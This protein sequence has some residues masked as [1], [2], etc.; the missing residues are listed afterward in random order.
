MRK[1]IALAFV[2][3]SSYGLSF[4]K[5]MEALSRYNVVLVH[6]AAPESEGFEDQCDGTV[7]SAWD[8]HNAWVVDYTTQDGKREAPKSLGGAAGMLGAYNQEGDVKLTLWLDSAVFEDTITY[9]S[10]YIYIQRAFANPAASPAHNAHEIGDRTWKG[11]NNCSVRRSLFEEAQEVRVQ[12]STNLSIMRNDSKAAYR[13]IPSRNILIAHSMGGVASHEYVTDTNV[14]NN[15]VD[16]VITLDSPHEGTGSLNLL[17]DMRDYKQQAKEASSQFLLAYV[18]SA[19]RGV[20]DPFAATIL[21]D[22]LAMTYGTSAM[23]RAV[24]TLVDKLALKDDYGF[25]EEDSLTQYIYPASEGITSLKNRTAHENMPMV[26]LLAGKGGMTFSDPNEGFLKPALNFTVPEAL[27]APIGNI[28]T[29]LKEGDGSAAAK[30]VNSM[31]GLGLGYLGAITLQDIGTTLIPEK[32]GL[33]EETSA[34]IDPNVD[35]RRF[36][37][38]AAAHANEASIGLLVAENVATLA[39]TVA[40]I[41]AVDGITFGSPIVGAE[42]KFA[43]ALAGA[44]LLTLEVM[45]SGV[46]DIL[47]SHE[48]AKARRMLDTLYSAEFSYNKVM[49]GDVSGKTL[50]MED[51]LYEKPFVNLGLFVS[52]D[53]LRDVDAGC[54]YEADKADKEQL[55][56]IGLYGANGDIVDMAGRRNYK[57]F[58]KSPLA[59]KSSSDWSSI[60][61]KMD[62]WERV[63]GLKPDGGENPGGVP[64]RHVE[65]YNV[66]AITVD[67]WIEKYSF[68]VDDLMPHRLRQIRLNFNYKEEIAWECDI[69]KA[70]TSSTAC[71]VFGRSGGGSWGPV[72]SRNHAVLSDGR[73]IVIMDTIRGV[74]HPVKKNGLFEFEPRKYGFDN[75]LAI[76]KDNQNTVAISTV[77]KIGAS[78][79]QRFYYLYKATANKLESVWPRNDVVLNK[80]KDFE[81]YASALGYE[82]FYVMNAWDTFL[83]QSGD[84]LGSVYSKSEMDMELDTYYDLS[85]IGTTGVSADGL[86]YDSTSAYFTSRQSDSD[87]AEGDYVW[88]FYTNIVNSTDST[89]D[90]NSYEIPFKVDRT[91]PKFVVTPE[92]DFTNPSKSAFVARYKWTDSVNEPD[93]RAMRW[94]LESGCAYRAGSTSSKDVTCTNSMDLT[95]FENVGS[96]DFAMPW[97]SASRSFAK[98]QGDGLYR[99]KVFAVDNAVSDRASYVKMSNLENAIA[100]NPSKVDANLWPV[101][102]DSLNVSTEYAAFIVDVTA[103]KLENVVAG[104]DSGAYSPYA[105]LARPARDSK[106][107]YAT[108]DSLLG[109][110]YQV[111]ENLNGRER[112]PVTVLWNFVHLGDTSKVDRAGDSVWVKS[113]GIATAEWREASGMRLEDGDYEIRA[114]VSDA[115]K[116]DS[117]YRNLAKIRV[118]KTAPTIFGLTSNRL[119]YPD[120]V[121]EFSA[122]I[123]VNENNDVATNR[124]GMRC[125]YRVTDG[126]NSMNWK[127]VSNNVLGNDSVTFEMESVGSK[128]GLRYLEAACVDAAGN[129]SLKTDIFYVGTRTPMISSPVDGDP[130]NANLVAIAGIAP[131]SGNADSMHTIYRLRY[132]VAGDTVW[133]TSNIFV[134]SSVQNDSLANVSKVSQ[135]NDG[136]LGYINRELPDGSLLSGTY[137]IEL[138]TFSAAEN[139]MGVDSLWT[140]DTAEVFFGFDADTTSDASL[141]FNIVMD[142]D[143]MKAGKDSLNLS[144]FLSGTFDGDYFMRI[145]AEDAKGVGVFEA[146]SS[147]VLKNPYYGLPSDTLSDTSA[148]WFYEDNGVYHLQWNGLALGDSLKIR[149]NSSSFDKICTSADSTKSLDKCVVRAAETPE[150]FDVLASLSYADGF[151][152]LSTVG[153]TDREMLV[154]G[155]SGH[156]VV[157]ANGAFAVSRTAILDTLAS[158]MRVYF[159]S[160]AKDGFYWVA[161]GISGDTL[162]PLATGWSV[163]PEMYGLKYKWDGILSTGGYPADGLMKIYA[164]AFENTSSNPHAFIDSA[165]VKIKLDPVEIA[166]ASKLPDFIALKKDDSFA[167]DGS[168]SASCEYVN[169]ALQQMSVSFGIKNRESKVDVYVMKNGKIVATLLDPTTVLRAHSNDSAYKV[170]WNSKNG[171]DMAELDEGLYQ[172]KIVATPV[173]G[174]ASA[175]KTASFN[176]KFAETMQDLSPDNP[177]DLSNRTPSIFVSEAFADTNYPGVFR[178]EP[179]ADYLI[180]SNVEYRYMNSKYKN[181][182]SING[183]ISG[184]QAVYGYEPKHFSLAIKRHRKELKLVVVQNINYTTFYVDC[185]LWNFNCEGKDEKRHNAIVVDTLHFTESDSFDTMY[186]IKNANPQGKNYYGLYYQAT[187]NNLEDISVFTLS[188]WDEFLKTYPEYADSAIVDKDYGVVKSAKQKIWGLNKVLS[189]PFN[190]PAPMPSES[191]NGAE[192]SYS[193]ENGDLGCKSNIEKDSVCTYEMYDMNAKLFEIKVFPIGDDGHFYS[194]WSKIHEGYNAYTYIT[195]AVE[196]KIPSEYWNADFGMDNLVNRTIRFDHTDETIYGNGSDGYLNALVHR[197]MIPNGTYFDGSAW[198]MDVGYGLLTPFEVQYLPMFPATW[199]NGTEY[200]D[201]GTNIFLF[202]DE[203]SNHP[204]DARF[205]ML[206]YGENFDTDYFQV[207]AVGNVAYG[208]SDASCDYDSTTNIIM[209][210]EAVRMCQVSAKSTNVSVQKTP[211]FAGSSGAMFYVGRNTDWTTVNKDDSTS[212]PADVNWRKS[213]K[214][215]CKASGQDWKSVLDGTKPC[216]KYYDIASKIHYYYEDYADSTW[217][218]IFINNDGTLKNLVNAPYYVARHP[219]NYLNASMVENYKKGIKG[220]SFDVKP[221]SSDYDTKTH[222]FFIKLDSIEKINTNLNTYENVVASVGNLSLAQNDSMI[223]WSNDSLHIATDFFEREFMYRKSEDLLAKP[224]ARPGKDVIPM[225]RLYSINNEWIKDVTLKSAKLMQLDSS[226]HSHLK[227]T[228]TFSGTSDIYVE[229]KSADSIVD[230]RVKEFVELQAFLKGGVTYQLSYLNDSAFYS[231]NDSISKVNDGLYHLGWF[232]VNRLNGNTQFLLT[233][234]GGTGSSYYFSKF[235]MIVGSDVTPSGS[236][237]VKSPLE[238]VEVTFPT[239]ALTE[240]KDV[241]VRISNPK[242][243]AFGVFNNLA[244]N[245][246]IVEV[247]PSM[248]FEN[249]AALPRIQMKVSREEMDA[250]HTTPETIK[251]YKVDF[252]NKEFVPLENALYGYLD[253]NGAALG[254]LGNDTAAVCSTPV[255]SRCGGGDSTWAYLLISAETRTFSVFTVLDSAVAEVPNFDLEILPEVAASTD[256]I[257]DVKGIS[258]FNLYVD[259]DSLWNDNGDSTAK[260]K[261]NYTLDS[262]GFAHIMLPVRGHDIDTNYVFVVAVSVDSTGKTS[263][264]PAAPAFARALTVNTAF[265]CSV[266]ED[267]LWLGLD[268]GYMAYGATCTHPGS[269]TVA[270]YRDGKLVTEIRGEIPDTIVYDGSKTFGSSRIGKIPSGVYESR[271][272]GVSAIG[273][274][275][276]VAGPLVY[277]DSMRPM[278]EN[279]DVVDSADILD[280]VFVVNADVYDS[281]S[282]VASVIVVPV[283]GSDTLRV[284]SAVPDSI[285][286]VK[287]PVRLSRKKLDNCTGCKLTLNFRVED[288]GHNHTDIKHATNKL[289]PFPAEIALW[290]PA[291]EETGKVAY[292]NLGTGHNL[293]L[294]G[295]SSSWL[296]DVGLYFSTQDSAVGVGSVDLGESSAYSFEARIKRGNTQAK[297]WN[298]V[299]GFSGKTGLNIELQMKNRD[300]RIVE[301]SVVWLAEKILPTEKE[302]F[303]IVVTVDSLNANFYVNGELA[304]SVPVGGAFAGLDRELDGTFSVGKLSTNS[305]IGNIADIRMYRGALVPEQV[306]ALVMPI[307]DDDET[308]PEAVI[309]AVDDMEMENG[310]E[311]LFSCSVAG[312]HYLASNGS[313]ASLKASAYVENSGDFNIIVYARST[314]LGSISV[315]AGENSATQRGTMSLSN[316]WRPVTISGITLNLK[317]GL[318]EIAL[319]VP[320]GIQIGGMALVT[321]AYPESAIAWGKS[322]YTSNSV[323]YG[324]AKKVKTYLR[325]EGYPETSTLRPR[326]RVVNTSD[327]PVNGFSVRY[328]FRGE[329]ASQVRTN[330]YWP[331]N[332]ESYPSV[333]SES[334]NTGYVEW[335]F[336][337]TIP[338]AGTVF[339][340]DGP[341]FGVYNSNYAPW[342]AL[343]DPSYV[344]MEFGAVPDKDGFFEDAGIIVLDNDDNLIG[345]ACAEMEDAISIVK[346]IKVIASDVRNDVQSSEIHVKVENVGNVS[347]EPFEMRYYFRV[348]GGLAVDYDVY[349]WGDCDR[350]LKHDVELK[351]YGGTLWGLSMRCPEPLNAGDSWK[352]P[353][354]ASLRIKD[355]VSIWNVSDDPSHRGLSFDSSEA[356]GICV[357]DSLGNLI[358]G[359]EP[360]SDLSGVKDSAY[361]ADNG[362]RAPGNSIPIVRTDDGLVLNLNAYTYLSLDL[363]NVV[364]MPIRNVF[365]GT[366]PPGEQM[367]RVNWSGINMNNTYLVLR[368]NGTIK[369]TKLLSLM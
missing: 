153:H 337:E 329:D 274:D 314:S 225:S 133:E 160:S 102:S 136:V 91:A 345:G 8:F 310:L 39:T 170:T 63:D 59:F 198:Q 351:N 357:Y 71:Q 104:A 40:N 364:G 173:D 197:N 10:D 299:L 303:H 96:Y 215:S 256:R 344:D 362:Y 72:F 140:T 5:P 19:M 304:K 260:V 87:P 240:K 239:S 121:T 114:L 58:R 218:R 14:Y 30:Y 83:K 305:F 181:G 204:Q 131:P 358:Y 235:D 213:M 164:E 158:Q 212:Y 53:S 323:A 11:N 266:P 190:F 130:I 50:L 356:S 322:S 191:P 32:S 201:N 122:T 332:V 313:G 335:K 84:S 206:F 128:H 34:F 340:G 209:A 176:V 125:Y 149:F 159:G 156:L 325:Y 363:V 229:F 178:Y 106:Y 108:Y 279:F 154:T 232:N 103:P 175:T 242:D 110:S 237:T 167:C 20:S 119:V 95:A 171:N 80:I 148:V 309:I 269:G 26:R 184:K 331:D 137:I 355:W 3:A 138:G 182:I 162:N 264:L 203:D 231:I 367:V 352:N 361:V 120:S 180:K 143:S 66:P 259:D 238:E 46:E 270:L 284:V 42:L 368:V 23:N 273:M 307:A 139:L 134:N 146:T 312:N 77:N 350:G 55:C 7:S 113:I 33:A 334:A 123:K 61:M 317:T 183:D 211:F 152:E 222:S 44:G 210:T 338:V 101:D 202:A 285:G 9:G 22:M 324:N 247:R 287:I 281:E 321:P 157:R 294:K 68:V 112:A 275:M 282:G 221:N 172:I 51:F 271:Y 99:I 220:F 216:Y 69:T 90:T 105:S 348:E 45:D 25:K 267:S 249:K 56:E 272:V 18:L 187:D 236:R 147:K 257:I 369:S 135:S 320:S 226:E 94:T 52:A 64:I 308:V 70:D 179:T 88:Q 43:I 258:N 353:V 268:N 297:T 192:Y 365:T 196:F 318:H 85:R 300:L 339:G 100:N 346:K 234:N 296:S 241:T 292:E 316:V 194:P 93:I 2:V 255:D 76:Q 117:L 161:N 214:N 92:Y 245:G 200:F 151:P 246:P 48:N 150:I 228:E 306:A 254:S 286:N 24:T 74:P 98:K 276:Q 115:A 145:Y 342:N 38:D 81:A 37:F 347:Q 251:L 169:F 4:A 333:H 278:V 126:T 224:L 291:R 60:G 265:A 219:L 73:E 166:L 298:R 62:R 75:L 31:T 328:Y 217:N 280:R 97:D 36:T 319:K 288:F 253:A 86:V 252:D 301:D 336:V 223:T 174:S 248:T 109:I 107:G 366:L 177:K 360:E 205:D 49:G 330:R 129:V 227:L 250:M 16:K 195:F 293:D 193:N 29:Q 359:E 302:W 13:S 124:T 163:N 262:T 1:L 116:N 243:H 79:T 311:R 207:L 27:S 189:S 28:V 21:V 165:V 65:R 54:F 6:G 261:L 82:E 341:H 118:D 186:V 277:T 354:K 141:Q 244:L 12:G 35:V 144:A 283:F 78:N 349:D 327:K 41:L 185:T 208:E 315:A 188:G 132:K 326:I 295:M 17:I 142:K 111:R 67:N 15:D 290:Y 343:D 230:K 199:K 47:S 289:Y 127:A 263:E 233:W 57:E 155:K 89:M 168:D